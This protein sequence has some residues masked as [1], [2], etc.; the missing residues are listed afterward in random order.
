MGSGSAVDVQAL[1]AHRSFVQQ[2]ARSLLRDGNDADDVAQQTWRSAVVHGDGTV[3]NPRGWLARITRHHA[4]NLVRGRNRRQRRE[5]DAAAMPMEAGDPASIAERVELAERVVRAMMA[6]EEPIRST[7]LLRFYDDRSTR[8]IAQAHHV[9]IDA[10]RWRIEKGLETLRRTLDAKSSGATKSWRKELALIVGASAVAG[11]SSASAS[12]AAIASV[13]IVGVALGVWG[14]R[15]GGRETGEPVESSTVNAV[16]TAA[17]DPHDPLADA[18]A[19]VEPAQPTREAVDAP[20]LDGATATGELWLRIGD[21]ASLDAAEVRP[22]TRDGV[23]LHCLDQRDGTVWLRARRGAAMVR[24]PM[25]A[26]G[27][28]SVAAEAARLAESAPRELAPGDLQLTLSSSLKSLGV[29]FVRAESG[30]AYRV[31]VAAMTDDADALLRSARIVF[32]AVPSVEGGGILRLPTVAGQPSAWVRDAIHRGVRL[33]EAIPGES[34]ARYLDGA[35]VLSSPFTAP[36]AIQDEAFLVVESSL[37]TSVSIDS[38]SGF[39]AAAGVGREGALTLTQYGA[40]GVLGPMSGTIDVESYGY[41]CLAGPLNGTLN[42]NSYATVVLE[43]DLVGSLRVR[44]YTELLLRGRILGTLD[45]K[46]SGW[47]DFWFDGYWTAAELEALGKD[48]DQVTLH[49]RSSDLP[50]GE[51]EGFGG[52]RKVIVGDARFDEFPR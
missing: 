12:I 23:D 40:I 21:G 26:L 50:I 34:F 51:H 9:S 39:V 6:L 19:Q 48:A 29:G 44:S 45:T 10:V 22:G 41:V 30:A 37:E 2:L 36:T 28:P 38:S 27:L 25:T 43:G 24:S 35:Y 20:S 15:D 5:T 3:A 14:L 33:G 46:S 1:L 17:Q 52:W 47:C 18:V 16:S 49:V 32:E 7:L 13:A 8:A 31:H 11:S 42:I 4:F